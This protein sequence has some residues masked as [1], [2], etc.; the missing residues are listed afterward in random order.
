MKLN[1]TIKNVQRNFGIDINLDTYLIY[2]NSVGAAPLY[3]LPF[4]CDT[5]LFACA[6]NQL[7]ITN[8]DTV[9]SVCN[10]TLSVPLEDDL[11]SLICQNLVYDEGRSSG[12]PGCNANFIVS[13]QISIDRDD[14]N[15]PDGFKNICT[16]FTNIIV[17]KTVF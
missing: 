7:P 3:C 4:N 13:T 9:N 15:G 5:T 10:T 16:R 6:C 11:K 1:A 8:L 12:T 14:G 2:E 17:N